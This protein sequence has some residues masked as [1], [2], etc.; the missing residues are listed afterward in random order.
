MKLLHESQCDVV[1]Y[2][3]NMCSKGKEE[4]KNGREGEGRRRGG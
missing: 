1:D 4:R 3:L 2:N